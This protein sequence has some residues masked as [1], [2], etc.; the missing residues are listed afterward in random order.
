MKVKDLI[1]KLQALDPELTVMLP[2]YEGGWDRLEGLGV[3]VVALNVNA[4]WYYGSHERV[5]RNDDYPGH[6]R[7]KAVLLGA[8]EPLT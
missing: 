8:G 5:H 3:S 7:V 2:G 4:A 6:D 1:E